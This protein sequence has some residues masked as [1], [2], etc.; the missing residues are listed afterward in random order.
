MKLVSIEIYS[1]EMAQ[2]AL[3]SGHGPKSKDVF[4]SGD[5]G[6]EDLKVGVT[7]TWILLAL[8]LL[9]SSQVETVMPISHDVLPFAL[10][11]SDHRQLQFIINPTSFSNTERRWAQGAGVRP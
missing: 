10:F 1:Y 3:E 11:R 7:F 5:L 9:Q 6:I 4:S 2:V 8:I